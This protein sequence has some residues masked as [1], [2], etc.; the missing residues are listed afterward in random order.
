MG[1]IKIN[2]NLKVSPEIEKAMV[3]FKPRFGNKQDI[4]IANLHYEIFR[5]LTLAETDNL[6][7]TKMKQIT[8]TNKARMKK[9]KQK[10]FNLIWLLK[11]RNKLSTQ[12][13]G[14]PHI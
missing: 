9:I 1:K 12:S 7:R 5:L 11:N 4:A 6:R 3:R 2:Q 10:E 8:K 13:T 14:Y